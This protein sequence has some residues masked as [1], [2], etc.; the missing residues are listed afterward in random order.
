MAYEQIKPFY[1]KDMGTKKGLCLQNVAKGFH[2]YPSKSPSSSAVNDMN[3]NKQKGT[4]HPF[5]TLPENVAV[6]VYMDTP[7]KYE[8]IIVADKGVFY[9]DGR[10]IARPASKSVFGWGEW[11]NGYQIVKYVASPS[12]F[13]PKKG[14]WGIRDNDP[15][16]G[17]LCKWF[18]DNYYGYFCKNPA[19]AH[20]QLDGNLFGKYCQKWVKQFQKNTG[21]VPD[22]YVGKLTYAK[23]KQYGF[24]G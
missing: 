24:K 22:G 7:S 1:A 20:K 10:K 6:P 14:W 23:L 16:I 15:R 9:S 4:L 8:H 12:G 2:I 21:L 19:Q 18:A 3:R 17:K 11:C 13:L 5:N